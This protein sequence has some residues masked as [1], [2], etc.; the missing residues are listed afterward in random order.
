[1]RIAELIVR[2]SQ[3]LAKDQVEITQEDHTPVLFFKTD[4]SFLSF[5]MELGRLGVKAEIT[6]PQQV[7]KL[8]QDTVIVS[9][10]LR[11]PKVY[12]QV[13]KRGFLDAITLEAVK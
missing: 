12:F 11:G 6:R 4:V 2:T 7:V 13:D 10:L 9:K 5:I 3:R 8:G 1:M